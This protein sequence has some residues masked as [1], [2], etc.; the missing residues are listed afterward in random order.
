[1]RVEDR[2]RHQIGR[3]TASISE[4]HP[5]VA[6]ALVFVA[7]SVDPLRDIR[8]L[9]VDQTF[10]RGRLP[11]KILLFVAD[12]AN[13]LARHL[14]Q[15]FA[16]DRSRAADFAGEHHAIG[17][18]QRLDATPRLWFDSQKGVDDRVGNAVANLVG[19]A[20]RHRL[21]GEHEIAV[22]Q[23]TAFPKASRKTQRSEWALM[24][25]CARSVKGRFSRGRSPGLIGSATLRKPARRRLPGP[26]RVRTSGA[27]KPDRRSC[28]RR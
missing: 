26:G 24:Q 23:R 2:G 20:L 18:N 11:M 13:R 12:L 21:A 17:R 14:D 7:G 19:M 3:L 28:N 15:P 10:D 5:L 1:M 6:G 4:H 16:G 9:A 27:A 8:R 25:P 22:G